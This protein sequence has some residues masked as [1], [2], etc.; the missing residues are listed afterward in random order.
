[1]IS[2]LKLNGSECKTFIVLKKLQI[3]KI[4]SVSLH[5]H[6]LILKTTFLSLGS[7]CN[8]A[9]LIIEKSIDLLKNEIGNLVNK[10]SV[11]FSMPWGF[12]SETKFFNQVVV[13]ETNLEAEKLL[14]KINKIEIELGK[15]SNI[16]TFNDRNIDIDILFYN[17]QVFVSENLCIP[18]PLLHFRLFCLQPLCEI[19]PDLKHTV[20]NKTINELLINYLEQSKEEP[21]KIFKQ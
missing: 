15:T 8:E 17:N 13:F 5:K 7:N 10:S 16:Q 19:N 11:F 2:K 20:L 12:N 6:F 4:F 9:I 14:E 21:L 3:K 18:H 1:M